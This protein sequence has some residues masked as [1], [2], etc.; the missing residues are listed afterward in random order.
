MLKQDLFVEKK[1]VFTELIVRITALAHFATTFIHHPETNKLIFGAATKNNE[2]G[3][4]NIY[5]ELLPEIIFKG[6]Y[7]YTN[8]DSEICME[9]SDPDSPFYYSRIGECN[10]NLKGDLYIETDKGK[11]IIPYQCEG[12][13]LVEDDLYGIAVS[14]VRMLKENTCDENN[15]LEKEH[16]SF[17][18]F[19]RNYIIPNHDFTPKYPECSIS[20]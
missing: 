14:N 2:N 19:D 5:E 4:G 12:D 11:F 9:S 17:Y 20:E 6:Y 18:I 16:I 10:S 7:R 1:F 3:I 15:T 8:D 13:I